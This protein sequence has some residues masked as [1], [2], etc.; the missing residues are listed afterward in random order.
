MPLPL[1]VVALAVGFTPAAQAR[2][3]ELTANTWKRR[4]A[5]AGAGGF[6]APFAALSREELARAREKPGDDYP[7]PLVRADFDGR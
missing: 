5:D 6:W 1:A 2:I 4:P 3:R 7:S